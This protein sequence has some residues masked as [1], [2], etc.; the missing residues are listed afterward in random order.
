MS[1]CDGRVVSTGVMRMECIVPEDNYVRKTREFAA[2][3][4]R[5]VLK[6]GIAHCRDGRHRIS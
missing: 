6:R 1:P 4:Q 5:Q 3:P 2:D